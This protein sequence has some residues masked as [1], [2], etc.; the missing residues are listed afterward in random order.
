M[1]PTMDERT[2]NIKYLLMSNLAYFVSTG[3]DEESVHTMWN[4]CLKRYGSEFVFGARRWVTE[5]YQNHH[6]D[7]VKTIWE[8]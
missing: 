1:E 7:R 6:P 2:A 5:Q 8:W 4:R 3:K